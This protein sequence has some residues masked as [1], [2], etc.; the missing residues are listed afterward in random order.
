MRSKNWRIRSDDG[1]G[2]S[3]CEERETASGG[4]GD[5]SLIKVLSP[6]AVRSQKDIWVKSSGSE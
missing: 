2:V 4:S 3:D 6:Q 1:G 5:G